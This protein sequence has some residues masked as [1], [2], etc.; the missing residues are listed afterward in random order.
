V[1]ETCNFATAGAVVSVR[2]ARKY[3]GAYG[4]LATLDSGGTSV[5][6]TWRV[7]TTLDPGFVTLQA[8]ATAP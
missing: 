4:V 6:S 1:L 2:V 7:E 8:R 5:L 3:G